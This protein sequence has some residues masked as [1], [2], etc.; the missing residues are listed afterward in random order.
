MKIRH[1]FA[2]IWVAFWIG[3]SSSKSGTPPEWWSVKM[4]S[5]GKP[6]KAWIVTDGEPQKSIYSDT[7][8]FKDATTGEWVSVTGDVIIEKVK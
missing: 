7:W 6:I 8:G 4:Y 1:Y 2:I 5:G 3:C